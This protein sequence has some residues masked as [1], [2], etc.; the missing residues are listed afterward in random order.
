MRAFVLTLLVGSA[1]GWADESKDGP[2]FYAGLGVATLEIEDEHRGV[3]LADS[4]L[5]LAPY[6][7]FRLRDNLDI[8]A[9]YLRADHLGAHDIAGSGIARLDIDETV[10]TTLVR[11]IGR[12]S[13]SEWLEWRRSWQL[14]GA[15]GYYRTAIDRTVTTLNTGARETLSEEETGLVLGT[16][17]LYEM[18]PVELRGYVEWFGVLADR[19]AW[20]AGVAVQ[21]SF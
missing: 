11:A 2:R 16:G 9:A 14:Y 19:E 1:A 21:V 20:D 18:G 3:E 4:A 15:I 17:V 6:G 12:F 13:L 7:G 5:A 8:E 10:A